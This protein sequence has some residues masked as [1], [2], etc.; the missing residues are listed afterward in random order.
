MGGGGGWGECGVLGLRVF[1]VVGTVGHRGF[2]YARR[3]H[4]PELLVRTG[5]YKACAVSSIL[6]RFAQNEV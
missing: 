4:K 1:Q 5:L 2:D 6:E 3:V